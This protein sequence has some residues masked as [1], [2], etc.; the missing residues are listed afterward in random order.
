MRT[1]Q[2]ILTDLP[3]ADLPPAWQ[4][5]DLTTFSSAK[6][7]WDYQQEA[8]QF[9]LKA[10]WKYF[11]DFADYRDGE[12]ET[13]NTVRKEAFWHWYQDNGL[14]E[15][16]DIPLSKQRRDIRALLEA[17]Y[18]A[19][20]GFI[21]YRH[22][23]NRMGF[24]MATGSG[25]SLVL[26]KLIELLWHLIRRGEI[27]P[28]PVL[29]LTARDDL[30]DQLKVHVEEFNTGRSDFRIHLQDLKAYPEIQRGFLP[31]VGEHDLT[32]FFYRADNLSDEQKE[33]I[34]DFRNYENNGRWY[35]L[36]DEAH[37]GDKEDSKRQHIYS[38]LSRN[39]FL[40]NFSATFT[41]PRDILTTVY[42]F[43]LSE[44]VRAGYGKHIT[45]LKQENRAFSDE[46]DYTGTEKQRVVLKALLMLAYVRKAQE[47]LPA[48]EQAYHRPLMLTLVNSVNTEDADLKL[49]FRELERIGRGEVDDRV[50]Q[51]AR[52]ELWTELAEGPELVFEGERFHADQSLFDSITPT[53][54]LRLVYNAPAPGEIE[55]LLR[56]SNRQEMAFKL[57]S[58]AEPF[59]LIKI[60][61][62]SGW[63]KEELEGYEVTEGYE[64]EGFFR[65]LNE[66]DS[67]INILMGSRTFYEGWDSNRPNVIT[68]INIGTGTEAKK[69]ILQ[70]VG[71]G[72][73]IEPL[74]GQRKR[75]LALYNAKAVDEDTFRKLNGYVSPLETLF[76][77]GTNRQALQTVIHQLD[78]EKRREAEHEISLEV[79]Q[80]AIAGHPLLIPVYRE[81]DHTIL[82]S[83]VPCKFEIAAD[84][85]ELMK[86]YMAYLDDDRLLLARHNAAPEDIRLLQRCFSQPDM[87]FNASNGRRFGQLDLLLS[88]L[89]AYFR[90]IPEEV[91]GLK[92][93]EDEICHFR[94]IKV[95]LKDIKELEEKISRV[96]AAPRRVAEM[97]AKYEAGQLSFEELI[98]QA[99]AIKEFETFNRHGYTL[100]IK[101]I[102]NHYYVPVLLSPSEKI[103]YIRHVIRHPSEAR[104]I[105]VLECYLG[106]EDNAFRKL[107]WWSFSKIDETLD[108]VYIPY[109]DPN[110]NR[111]RRFVP[112]FIFWLQ[113]ESDYAIV[114][115]DPKGMKHAE[116]QHKVDGF[117][118]IFRD[119]TGMP[120]PLSFDGL[121]VQVHL[122]LYTQDANR[123][124]AGYREYWFDNPAA[125]PKVLIGD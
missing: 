70:S 87:Y 117:R 2:D 90:V 12:P 107:D 82:Q 112:D 21:P 116:Y 30:L 88:R 38:I 9:A 93:L 18:P 92:P 35:V 39:G 105:N 57:K 41:D 106:Q 53:E 103:D 42:N 3:F 5:H 26:I 51:K 13:T 110:S 81:A 28:Y 122:F 64:D 58:A 24:W 55:V 89:F 50:W 8:L 80:E 121:R 68:Y 104:F 19:E 114:F 85:L 33:R 17:Y 101:R 23:I 14:E 65:R 119:K 22:F 109:Y 79:N 1:L 78:Q 20:D 77:F 108:E 98:S 34:V 86:H 4:D 63:L 49:F 69:F 73:R 72:V 71:R 99:R 113:K 59:A 29:V 6:R 7:L 75:L 52:K 45:I 94:H 25:K 96:R 40:F 36:L 27:P 91:E 10:L 54:L 124:P 76:I 16:L 32:V 97:R 84:E 111:I 102:A 74:P 37:K 83:R 118:Q 11:E 115:V 47:S 43:N 15:N 95:F 46:E 60:G 120:K 100:Y 67:P 66:E 48:S 123:A 31:I 62:I 61:D 56:P 125:I 44:F